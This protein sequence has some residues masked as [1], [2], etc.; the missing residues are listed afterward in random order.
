MNQLETPLVAIIG[1][2]YIGNQLLCEFSKHHKVIGYDISASRV[3]ELR[4][5]FSTKNGAS[6]YNGQVCLTTRIQDLA[7]ATHFL[8]SVPTTSRE[9]GSVDTTCIEDALRIVTAIALPG[10]T[11]VIES[12]VAVGTTR[13]LLGPIAASLGLFGGV[14]PERIDPGRMDPLPSNIP[15]LVAGLDDIVP[16]SLQAIKRL[17]STV[18][19]HLVAVSRPEVAEMTKLYENC[20]RLVGIA[21][22]NEIADACGEH[23]IDPSEVCSAAAT[24]PFGFMPYTPSIGVGGHCLPT[25]ARYLLSNNRLPLLESAASSTRARPGMIA[26]KI[27]DSFSY[28]NGDLIPKVLVVGIAY[29]KGQNSTIDSPGLRLIEALSR[30]EQVDVWWA[31]S[32]VPQ[33]RV[34]H[35]KRLPNEEWNRG[36]LATFDHITVAFIQPGT[37]QDPLKKLTGVKIDRW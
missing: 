25:N 28:H 34:P 22:A 13:A 7:M 26:Q 24:K 17:Y 36:T 30:F 35:I 2:G 31:D 11:V 9:D 37:E 12:S 29:K 32:L 16:G 8:I 14:S 21:F 18:F 15:K 5:Q 23:D 4:Q 33:S 27:V 19:R 20:Q 6:H 3:H 1:C 10:S